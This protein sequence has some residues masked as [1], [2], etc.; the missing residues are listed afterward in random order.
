M[1]EVIFIE[2]DSVLGDMQT[3]ICFYMNEANA[4]RITDGTYTVENGGILVNST[5]NNSYSTYRSNGSLAT[6][7]TAANIAVSTNTDTQKISF[8]GTFQAGNAIVTLDYTG[9]VRGMDLGEAVTG[10]IVCNEWKSVLKKWEEA[11]QFMFEAR[12][13]DNKLIILFDILHSGGTKLCPE[14]TYEVGDY[15]WQGDVLENTTDITY[16][17][18][19]A[20]MVAGYITVE[21][22]RGG[23]V[24]T[25]ELTDANGRE[26]AGTISGPVQNGTN[27]A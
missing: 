14:G 11:G 5:Y 6:D 9:E 25:F 12:S 16:N 7:I 4:Q 13:S 21:H 24:F 19:A 3:R 1:W 20:D 15:V 10:K 17:G 22:I 18:V 27:P 2:H 23:Y 26:F 8:N